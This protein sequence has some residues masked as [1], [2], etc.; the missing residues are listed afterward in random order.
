MVWGRSTLHCKLCWAACRWVGHACHVLYFK[1]LLEISL[2]NQLMQDLT[3]HSHEA[4]DSRSSNCTSLPIYKLRTACRIC[5][6]CFC[7]YWILHHSYVQSKECVFVFDSIIL[8][9]H[10]LL[11]LPANIQAFWISIPGKGWQRW[12]SD[13]STTSYILHRKGWVCK[14]LNQQFFPANFLSSFLCL[15]RPR[16]TC[17]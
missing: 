17:F 16:Y 9:K 5:D 8:W 6:S 12:V 2:K 14:W 15:N 3:A 10:F 1:I 13:L 11:F 4:D 7:R